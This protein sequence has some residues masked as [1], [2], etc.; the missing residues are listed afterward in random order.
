MLILIDVLLFS[1]ILHAQFYL[2]N[3]QRGPYKNYKLN[4]VIFLNNDTGWVTGSTGI[5][6]VVFKTYDGGLH[7]VPSYD[8]VAKSFQGVTFPTVQ[9]GYT[10][11]D[12]N[13]IFK[14]TD[15]G[16]YWFKLDSAPKIGAAKITSI[17]SNIVLVA[18]GG[19]IICSYDGGKSWDSHLFPGRD[20]SRISCDAS[21]FIAAAGNNISIG[22]G[23]FCVI[24]TDSGRTWT[25]SNIPDIYPTQGIAVVDS[26]TAFIAQYWGLVLVTTD[27][28]LHWE[29]IANTEMDSH[30]FRD[31]F[32]WGRN[33]I[34]VI[35]LTGNM[36]RTKDGGVSWEYSSRVSDWKTLFFTQNGI[37]YG[38]RPNG[39]L[40]W[41]SEMP[42]SY[43]K[44]SSFSF[45]PFKDTLYDFSV[46]ITLRWSKAN[47][48][49]DLVITYIIAVQSETGNYVYANSTLDTTLT[50]YPYHFLKSSIYR[51]TGLLSDG[52]QN[53]SSSDTIFLKTP[54]NF[55]EPTL[56]IYPTGLKNVERN[57]RLVWH[58][59][60][61]ANKYWVFA[62][63]GRYYHPGM[64]V[65]T[66]V[67]D[68]SYQ[69]KTPFLS[70]TKYFW[71]VGAYDS[72]KNFLYG[73]LDSLI[74]GT[75]I[76]YANRNIIFNPTQYSLSQNYPNPFNPSTV[77]N[78]SLPSRSRVKVQI[79]NTLG[80]IVA[81]P[82]NEE[83]E[84]GYYDE[85]FNAAH[86]ASGI[87]FYRIEAVDVGNSNNHFAQTKKMLLLR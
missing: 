87:Y 65:D 45:Y 66:S 64:P 18:G 51:V 70:N 37:M 46:P 79:I 76:L 16:L 44:P 72:A 78:F 57:P 31:I 63:T 38:I 28:G 27:R 20:I 47:N 6:G 32:A 83:R 17:D 15:G 10:Y 56:L 3:A 29:N 39:D 22:Y 55:N 67:F 85:H 49:I 50:F 24:S 80:Q 60:P 69:V 2:I 33:N 12:D 84:A 34:T 59:F 61:G 81:T 82:V 53:V 74:T 5:Y 54:E 48:P 41:C 58:S 4:D 19:S 73:R 52:F 77:I 62:D 86:L 40:L 1:N 75:S 35:T 8:S 13:S 21:G 71:G 7:W 14:T 25:E 30:L 43:V 42:K 26:M 9:I 68:T 36:Y 11:G 23:P